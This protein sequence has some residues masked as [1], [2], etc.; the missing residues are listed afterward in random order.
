MR[1]NRQIRIREVYLIDEKGDPIGNVTTEEAQRRADAAGLDLVEV[2]PNAR[3]PVAKIMDYGKYK[4][5]MKKK[6]AS[7]KG[8][9]T[10]V[11][12][13]RVH[14]QTDEHDLVVRLKQ[15]GKFLEQGD[16][17]L[18][19]CTF[20]GREMQHMEFGR[21]LMERFKKE[22]ELAGKVEKEPSMEGKR[23]TM[24][25]APHAEDVRK[26]LERQAEEQRMAAELE[27]GKQRRVITREEAAK[28]AA[29]NDVDKKTPAPA[30]E[31]AGKK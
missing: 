11:K 3:P 25:I 24:M 26:K 28:E 20:K 19:N 6:A 29:T 31:P 4:Y 27:G 17:V 14:P 15:A 10:K 18:V 7:Q 22:L 1:V 8:R 2:N 30:A 13:V 21:A 5:K 23:M 9:Q 12:E 16:K